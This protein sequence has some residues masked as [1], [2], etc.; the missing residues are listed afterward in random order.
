MLIRLGYRIIF[1]TPRPT[2]IVALLKVHPSR[3]HN[4]REPDEETFRRSFLAGS[5]MGVVRHAGD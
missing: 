4:L 3:A 1:D 5:R 2:Q